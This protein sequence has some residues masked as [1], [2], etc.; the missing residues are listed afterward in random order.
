MPKVPSQ[1]PGMMFGEKQHKP[2]TYLLK[3]LADNTFYYGV[4]FERGC[5]P[6]EFWLQYET[7]SKEVKRKIEEYGKDAFSF[8]IRKTFDDAE[9]A[10]LW[11]NKVLRR[12]KVIERDDF[13]N[14]TDNISIK[15]LYGSDNAMTRPDVIEAFKK[16]RAKNP[17][18][19]ASPK[20]VYD[21]L[22]KMFKGKKRPKDVCESISKALKG[23]KR[24]DDF[25]QKC[26]NRQLGVSPSEEN[27]RKKSESIKGRKRYTNGTQIIFR[28]PG[29]EPEGFYL[30]ENK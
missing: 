16:S 13:M 17:T 20:E 18:R 25:K 1:A 22:S 21:K 29:T 9:K 3:C 30:E 11:E 2:Y 26:R 24:S 14:K 23:K 27:K 5:R 15:P 4:K 12:M 8:E 10:R 7:S 6:E 19:K 28:H